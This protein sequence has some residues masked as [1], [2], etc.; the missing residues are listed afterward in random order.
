MRSLRALPPASIPMACVPLVLLAAATA[1]AQPGTPRDTYANAIAGFTIEIPEDWEMCT[2]DLGN[3]MI[4]LDA[5]AGIPTGAVYPVLWFF[6]ISAQPREMA[7]EIATGLEAM[8]HSSPAVREGAD[9]EW[10]VSASSAGPR[11]PL[12]EEWHCRREGNDAYVL[13]TMV[14]PEQEPSFRDDLAAAVASCRLAPHPRLK[15]YTEPSERAY[16]MVLPE[17]WQCQGQ[18]VRTPMVPG[19][20]Q[21]EASSPDGLAG[22]F[23]A[24]PAVLN[25]TVPYMPAAEAAEKIVLPALRQK[26]PDARL[27]AVHELPRPGEYYE[28]AIR[29]LGIGDRPQMD[30]VR[31]DYVAL[32]NGVAVRA[33]V[34]IGTVLLDAS[35]ILGDR[36]NWWLLT[37][38]YW[39]P[40][41]RFDEVG[42]VGRGVV[43]SVMTAPEFRRSQFEAAN[44]TAIWAAWNR[45]LSFWR[46]MVRLWST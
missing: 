27:V 30:K 43:A 20:F 15:L 41:E 45:E 32:R 29:R 14:R 38:G 25:V 40:E 5:D 42:P 3:T 22:A 4:A 13:A 16:R 44:E 1:L 23:S 26:L 9:G 33:R 8:D 39:A 18:I 7:A 17:D 12:I 21:W 31:A 46:F 37:S 34:T 35:A 6:R 10:I 19:Y 11:G 36:G 24:P 2:G 28:G